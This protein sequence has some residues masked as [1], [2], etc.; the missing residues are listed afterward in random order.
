MMSVFARG[1]GSRVEREDRCSQ[2]SRYWLHFL[3]TA[4]SWNSLNFLCCLAGLSLCFC[5]S[6][7]VLGVVLGLAMG[8]VLEVATADLADCLGHIQ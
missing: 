1:K 3:A 4:L 5:R 2:R 8:V 7:V 6:S